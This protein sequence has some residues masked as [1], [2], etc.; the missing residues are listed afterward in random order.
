MPSEKV[1]IIYLIA[2]QV[3]KKSLYNMNYFAEPYSHGRK[4]IKVELDSSN[5]ATK[6]D[7]EGEIGINTSKFAKKKFIQ[8]P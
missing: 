6:S 1:L 3:K 8:A 2:R 5:C 7:L 4:K